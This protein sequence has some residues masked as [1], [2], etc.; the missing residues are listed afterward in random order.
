MVDRQGPIASEFV[1]RVYDGVWEVDL[2]R[3]LR[4]VDESDAMAFIVDLLKEGHRNRVVGVVDLSMDLA[5]KV[6]RRRES[7]EEVAC[8]GLPLVDASSVFALLKSVVPRIGF[9]RTLRVIEK[10]NVSAPD[11]MSK[12]AYWLP[13]FAR[14]EAEK[15]A[16]AQCLA[17]AE[18]SG[19]SG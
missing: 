10:V 2:V 17:R 14:T 19:R 4:E 18:R 7:M 6:L 11:T 16:L 15:R 1:G 12:A 9:G 8:A 3:R 5:K 13:S